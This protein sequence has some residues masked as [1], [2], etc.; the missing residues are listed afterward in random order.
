MVRDSD[1]GGGE[2]G[3]EDAD[4]GQGQRGGVYLVLCRPTKAAVL[5]LPHLS[6]EVKASPTTSHQG[7]HLLREHR[8]TEMCGNSPVNGTVEAAD[9]ATPPLCT[10]TFGIIQQPH[11]PNPSEP[12]G[13][14]SAEQPLS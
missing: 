7:R 8:R 1:G 14:G 3:D 11:T 6:T 2:G 10:L 9:A 5:A 4:G 12:G 13:A